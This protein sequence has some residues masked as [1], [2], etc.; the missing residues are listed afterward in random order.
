M[1]IVYTNELIDEC[2]CTEIKVA[3]VKKYIARNKKKKSFWY[4]LKMKL[5]G[6][7]KNGK[8]KKGSV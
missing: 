6:G 3:E 7:K 5:K 4:K 1:R 8:N 2:Y